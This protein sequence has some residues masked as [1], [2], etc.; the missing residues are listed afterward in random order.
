MMKGQV[1]RLF[2]DEKGD[3]IETHKDQDSTGR[4]PP[5]GELQVVDVALIAHPSFPGSGR[6]RGMCICGTV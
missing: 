4:E 2:Y 5:A 3:F 6:K 1:A